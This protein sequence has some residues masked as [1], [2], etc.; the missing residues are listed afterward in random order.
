MYYKNTWCAFAVV[1]YSLWIYWSLYLYHPGF[2][3]GPDCGGAVGA[4][5][6]L[7]GEPCGVGAAS[8]WGWPT[9]T[10]KPCRIAHNKRLEAYLGSM[11]ILSW[12]GDLGDCL[13]VFDAVV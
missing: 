9:P 8:A 3:G 1:K 2:G 13:L 11:R 7:H 12:P 10:T 6:P 5:P 4:A